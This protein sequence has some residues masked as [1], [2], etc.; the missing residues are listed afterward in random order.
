MLSTVG[1]SSRACCFIIDLENALM[2]VGRLP[3]SAGL[4]AILCLAT[5]LAA[6]PVS[7]SV[8]YC[9]IASGLAGEFAGH[10]W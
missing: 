5:A 4:A 10:F 2:K 8:N 9:S 7:F 1:P 6:S 3:L